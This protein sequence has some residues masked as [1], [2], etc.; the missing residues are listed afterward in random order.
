MLFTC[1]PTPL[2]PLFHRCAAVFLVQSLIN[3]FNEAKH[4]V[5]QV[6]TAKEIFFS[7]NLVCNKMLKKQKKTKNQD[8]VDS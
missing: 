3:T 7:I 5:G 4:T 8:S 1:D 2:G 6:V